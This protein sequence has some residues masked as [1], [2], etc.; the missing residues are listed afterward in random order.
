MIKMHQNYNMQ[1][2]K[3]QNVGIISLYKH[4]T[5]SMSNPRTTFSTFHLVITPN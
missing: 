4:V 2:V 5:L 3:V 1:I